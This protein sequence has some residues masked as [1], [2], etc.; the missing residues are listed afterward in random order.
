MKRNLE[1]FDSRYTYLSVTVTD[2]LTKIQLCATA[3]TYHQMQQWRKNA[4]KKTFNTQNNYHQKDCKDHTIMLGVFH[5]YVPLK[6]IT[7]T[8][9]SQ[10]MKARY[11]IACNLSIED[12]RILAFYTM[13]S[14]IGVYTISSWVSYHLYHRRLSSYLIISNV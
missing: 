12:I 14:F 6:P 5:T 1:K 13:S 11:N 9:K 3:K 7:C 4:P 2:W 10:L 8:K